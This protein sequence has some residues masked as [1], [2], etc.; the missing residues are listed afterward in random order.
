MRAV[1]SIDELYDEVKDYGLVITNDIALETA[2]NARIDQP[3]IGVL[4]MTPRHIVQQLGPMILGEGFMTDL[5]LISKVSEETG[6]G[7]RHVY[8]EILNFRQ[9]RS[10]TKEVRDYLTSRSSKE[11]YRSYRA[12]PTL[13]KA[14]DEFEPDDP[15]VSWFFDKK[16][17]VAIIGVDLFD[18]LDKCCT[19][20]ECDLID[21]FKDGEYELDAIH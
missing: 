12:L 7:F 10:Y 15:R 16:G 13:E 3:R 20:A 4:A 21:N 2:L 14:M 17:G 1:K 19:P 9:I 18:Q 6:Y 5:Q 8:S 11:I